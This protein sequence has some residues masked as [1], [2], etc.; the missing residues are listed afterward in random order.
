[1]LR[2][3]VAAD[4]ASALCS[5]CPAGEG[6]GGA[7][8]CIVVVA[9]QELGK[10]PAPRCWLQLR[11]CQAARQPRAPPAAPVQCWGPADSPASR[12]D[13]SQS[14]R[15]RPASRA[16]AEGSTSPQSLS[17]YLPEMPETSSETAHAPQLWG[18]SAQPPVPALTL[19]K[20]RMRKKKA[21]I[22]QLKRRMIPVLTTPG[23]TL[24][25]VTPA[26]RHHQHPLHGHRAAGTVPKQG[27]ECGQ[28]WWDGPGKEGLG[29]C[30]PQG[31]K[32]GPRP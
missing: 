21:R 16:A 15:A 17:K 12:S 32:E 13:S 23:F 30:P 27:L 18:S 6:A 10:R 8:P 2:L 14:L 4:D 11:G 24:L 5:P 31:Q 1:M 3:P 19:M 28:R 22:G 9:P 29:P 26:R 25:V 7:Q 20:G